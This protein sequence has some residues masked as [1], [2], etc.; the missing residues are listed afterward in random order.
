V[1]FACAFLAVLAAVSPAAAQ[2]W[3]ARPVRIIVPF[4]PGGA[5]DA[6]PRIVVEK[7]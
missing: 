5:A 1:R 3:P 2:E 7:L 4:P 6:L